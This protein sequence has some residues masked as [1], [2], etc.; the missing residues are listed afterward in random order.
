MSEN[1]KK[2]E[3]SQIKSHLKKIDELKKRLNEL[4]E[5]CETHYLEET[6]GSG[7]I[8]KGWE[9][10]FTSKAKNCHINGMLK[11][12][13]V[14]DNERLFSQPLELIPA[15]STSS[16]RNVSALDKAGIDKSFTSNLHSSQDFLVGPIRTKKKITNSLGVKRNRTKLVQHNKDSK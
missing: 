7:N 8:L 2:I 13:K 3:L 9:H 11:K 15:F 14:N 5:N 16:D 10:I 4:I 6:S 1:E 12:S